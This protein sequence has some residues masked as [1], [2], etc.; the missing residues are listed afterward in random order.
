M[1]S[2]FVVLNPFKSRL[3]SLLHAENIFCIVVTFDVLKLLTSKLVRP[4][5]PSNIDSI[6]VTFDVLK[7]LTSRVVNCEQFANICSIFVTFSVWKFTL[8]FLSPMQ[9]LTSPHI[10][11]T[12]RVSKLLKSRE[13]I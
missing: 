7:L 5:Q 11:M 13:V 9:P 4:A 3:V 2:T 8:M 6:V 1:S 10:S 12:F